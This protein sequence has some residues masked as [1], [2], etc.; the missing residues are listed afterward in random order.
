MK[1]FETKIP[2][3]EVFITVHNEILAF[4][5]HED[6]AE[7]V[8]TIMVDALRFMPEGVL[9]L[10]INEKSWDM[11]AESFQKVGASLQGLGTLHK[12]SAEEPEPRNDQDIIRGQRI[13][14]KMFNLK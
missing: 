9:L 4:T 5:Y 10:S 7:A 2:T 1:K 12:Y 6:N 3:G 8:D 11:M 14:G 13:L